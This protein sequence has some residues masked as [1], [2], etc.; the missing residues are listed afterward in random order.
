MHFTKRIGGSVEAG[1]NAV[2]ALARE[3]YRKTSFNIRDVLDLATYPG[4]WRMSAS[5]LETGLHE[6]YRSRVKA[7]FVK[8]LRK[9]V[10]EIEGEDLHEPGAGVRAQAVDRKGQLLQDFSIAQSEDA[11]HVLNAPSPGA[12]S[13]LA[14]GR[15]MADL[16]GKSFGLAA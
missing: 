10:P 5:H 3:G 14:I 1:P 12:T 6:M 16:A 15:Y 13:S 11:V 7:S 9:L 4:F 8:S 2:L